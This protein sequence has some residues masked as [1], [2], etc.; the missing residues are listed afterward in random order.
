MSSLL[1]GSS[2]RASARNACTIVDS[3]K[4]TA[5]EDFIIIFVVS[6]VELLATRSER[7]S[8]VHYIPAHVCVIDF[9][10]IIFHS[11]RIVFA[12]VLS[13]SHTRTHTSLLQQL[14]C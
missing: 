13:L 11:A 6:F 1:S 4:Q 3:R 9:L 10:P 2:A 5:E 7:F 8:L 12:V 14:R